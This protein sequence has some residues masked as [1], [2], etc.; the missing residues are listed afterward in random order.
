MVQVVDRVNRI[1]SSFTRE[2]SVLTLSECA[3]SAGLAKSS[4]H[5]L[6]LS[7]ESSGLV[8]R[9]EAGWRLGPR[10][11]ALASIRLGQ[12]DLRREASPRLRELRRKLCAATAFSVPDG[13]DM[14]YVERHESP[15]AFAPSARLG[16]RAPMWAG[17]SGRAVLARMPPAERTRRLETSEWRALPE[18]VQREILAEVDAAAAR[19]WSIDRG[20]FFEGVA[21][22]AV[23]IADDWGRPVA[24]LSAIVPPERLDAHEAEAIG[25]LLLRER[26]ELEQ[27]LSSQ[28]PDPLAA[29]SADPK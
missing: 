4:A 6:L 21:A 10:V 19:G 12:L 9:H 23:A 18:A 17:A 14:V 24:A 5:R 13:G 16:G 3:S 11:I 2:R 22:V 25:A 28:W 7:L 27:V 15:Q 20:W 8:E 29:A 26:A 1:L